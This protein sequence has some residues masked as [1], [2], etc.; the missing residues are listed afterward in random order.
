MNKIDLTPN[1][2]RVCIDEESETITSGRAYS[3]TTM[4][5]IKFYDWAKLLIEIDNL[6]DRNGYPQAF[7]NKRSFKDEKTSYGYNY[8]PKL[9]VDESWFFSQIGKCKTYNIIIQ[10]R[11]FTGWQ[12]D[13]FDGEG[14]FLGHFTND[15][16]LLR[17]VLKDAS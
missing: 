12:G 4:N 3:P 14:T 15:L 8:R 10:A 9:E 16:Q 11:Q 13:L 7:Q 6:L 2:I 5:E 17:K 1:L